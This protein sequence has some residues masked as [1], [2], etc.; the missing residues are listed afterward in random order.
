LPVVGEAVMDAY[1]LAEASPSNAAAWGR[2]GMVLHA[3]Q[4]LA[5][6]SEAYSRAV[7]L[8]PRAFDWHYY[9]G[10]ASNRPEALRQAL[11]LRDY[12][13]ARIKLAELLLDEGDA[14]SAARVVEK[15]EHPAAYFLLGR[16]RNDPA[17]YRRALDA[18]P[19]FGAAMFALAQVRRREGQVEEA[20]RLMAAY[21]RFKTTAPPIDDPL[22][23]AV[24]A[25][26]R[27]P[28][29]LLRRAT[30]LEAQGELASAAELNRQALELD[31]KLVQA[32]INLVS[33]NARL[34]RPEAAEKHYRE[35][36]ALNPNAAE[37]HYNFGVLCFAQ[38]RRGDAKQAFERTVAIDPAN[39]QAWNNLGVLLQEQGQLAAAAERFERA[40]QADPNLRIA[41]FHLGR[42]RA[43]EG[44]W[45]E[46]IQQL[47]Q[48]APGNDPDSPRFLYA[49]GAVE[50][51]AGRRNDAAATLMR[52]RTLADKLGQMSLVA[53]IDRDLA[54]LKP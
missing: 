53:S 10:L 2:Y 22:F 45:T 30:A 51:R 28:T 35:A 6:A 1:R 17:L 42:I 54:R 16:A 14:E 32:H 37:A 36:V 12:A 46:A 21:P 38:G 43:N 34:N 18:F 8:D 25:L 7:A 27:G 40:L 13:P 31:P 3:H 29:S 5:A 39:A 49:L 26:D 15:V 48:I 50:A 33:A 24:T 11:K 52:A 9:L 19:Q 44:R 20:D 23:D 4:Q 41:R 47:R